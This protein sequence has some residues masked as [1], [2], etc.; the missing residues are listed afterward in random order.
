MN[1]INKIV[2]LNLR[3]ENEEDSFN[4]GEEKAF[5]I[6]KV[7]ENKVYLVPVISQEKKS[8]FPLQYLISSPQNPSCLTTKKNPF[9]YA[10]LNQRIIIRFVKEKGFSER[11]FCSNKCPSC[12][13][14]EKFKK[15][16]LLYN[17]YL[18]SPFNKLRTIKLNF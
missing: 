4:T 7:K 8:E 12:L 10:N 18:K 2:F 5:L 15:L 9:S 17:E 1:I 16:I 6:R 14:K 11:N 3:Y 13:S